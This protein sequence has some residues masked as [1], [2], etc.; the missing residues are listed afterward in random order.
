M[1]GRPG[2]TYI[3][4]PADLILGHFDVEMKQLGPIPETPRSTAPNNKIR[5]IV[6]A[7][8]SAKAP[9]IVLGKCA[10]Y[11][12]AEKQIRSLIEK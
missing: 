6:E 4:L 11:S 2:P 9:L 1:F 12:R 7:I 8:K 10:A 5:D 3:D